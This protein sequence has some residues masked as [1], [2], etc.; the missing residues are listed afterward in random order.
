MIASAIL[1]SDKFKKLVIRRR[2]VSVGLSLIIIFIY[3]GFILNIA[4][5]K[6]RLATKIGAHITLSL[7]IGFGIIV[8]AW[9]VTGCYVYWANTK[10][11]SAVMELKKQIN[12]LPS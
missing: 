1:N 10:Y 4:F 6:E 12:E 3:F 2:L 7:P 11:D 8:F 9:I 5:N